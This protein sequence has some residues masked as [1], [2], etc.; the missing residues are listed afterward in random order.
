MKKHIIALLVSL[1]LVLTSISVMKPA[2]VFAETQDSTTSITTLDTSYYEPCNFHI[3][4]QNSMLVFTQIPEA[5]EG[6][7]LWIQL[8][9]DTTGQKVFDQIYH[10]DQLPITI[11]L[12][13]YEDDNYR[14]FLNTKVASEGNGYRGYW[15][16]AG[17]PMF[18]KKGA[19]LSFVF[20]EY[21]EATKSMFD[22]MLTT[23]RHES[24]S[25]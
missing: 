18:Q 24:E 13:A 15:W 10:A 23:V 19:A 4:L 20:G 8:Q 21:Y 12:N 11:P 16:D 2:E 25:K 1:V 9:S 14:I 6:G 7:R 22:T 5:F 17:A 3:E